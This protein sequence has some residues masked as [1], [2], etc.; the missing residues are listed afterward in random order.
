MKAKVYVE[1]SILSNLAAR[2]SRDT[3]T[4]A[5]QVITRRWWETERAN[6]DLMVSEV[7]EAE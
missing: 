2:S 3:I 5:R 1:T 4:A 7:V 6:Y